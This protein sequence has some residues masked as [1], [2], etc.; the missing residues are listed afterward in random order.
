LR[1][2]FKYEQKTARLAALFFCVYP[3]PFWGITWLHKKQ[4]REVIL[5][6]GQSLMV[7]AE[8]VLILEGYFFFD[9]TLLRQ[10]APIV[11]RPLD[12][13]YRYMSDN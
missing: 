2:P 5:M 10:D 1:A 3:I 4:R 13:L 8:G 9:R 12:E 11:Q 7:P 6:D